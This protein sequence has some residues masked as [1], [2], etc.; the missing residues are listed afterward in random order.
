MALA[1]C[2]DNPRPVAKPL[3]QSIEY[4][5]FGQFLKGVKDR[6]GQSPDQRRPVDTINI[7]QGQQCDGALIGETLPGDALV[8]FAQGHIGNHG[9]LMVVIHF[10]VDAQRLA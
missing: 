1:Y 3:L 9:G 2:L 5:G 7:P 8:G 10:G 4:I 6:P